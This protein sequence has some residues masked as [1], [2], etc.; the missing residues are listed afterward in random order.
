MDFPEYG[1]SL[2]EEQTSIG[3]VLLL[4]SDNSPIT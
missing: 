1:N 2:D 3:T 4:R